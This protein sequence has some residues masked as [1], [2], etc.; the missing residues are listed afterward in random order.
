MKLIVLSRHKIHKTEVDILVGLFENGLKTFHLRKPGASKKQVEEYLKQIPQK[1]LNRIVLHSK[2][3]L[4]PKYGLKG[5]HLTRKHRKNKIRTWCYVHYLKAKHPALTVSTSFHSLESLIE[6]GGKYDYC[7]LSPI[8]NSISKSNYE[9]KFSD[10]NLNVAFKK[11]NQVIVALGGVDLSKIHKVEQMG[12][13]GAA[14]LGAIWTSP[15]P[16]ESFIKINEACQH[17]SL[18]S[19]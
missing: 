6:N 17:P 15:N 8:F 1:Y 2:H 9:G 14:V 18:A 10:L 3:H 16:L 12:F 7:F 13:N 11:L 5:I 4:A 19:V